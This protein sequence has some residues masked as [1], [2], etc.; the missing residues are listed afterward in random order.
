[1]ASKRVAKAT[2]DWTELARRVP[3]HQKSN[4]Q[5]FRAKS[6]GYLRK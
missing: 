1:M 6:D 4:L 5:A 2:I 3:V